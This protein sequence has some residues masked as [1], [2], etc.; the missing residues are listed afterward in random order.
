MKRILYALIVTSL[1]FSACK[2]SKNYLERSN[3]DRALQD[4]VK[5]LGKN[6]SD[7]DAVTAVPILYKSIVATRL[8]RIKSY[9]TGNELNRWDKIISEYNQLQSAYSSIINTTGAFKL[10]TPENYSTQL[11]E[12]KQN[13]AEGYYNYAQSFLQKDGRDNARK[14][15]TNFKKAN[16]Y[17]DGGYK[18]AQSKMNQAYENAIVDVM[19]NPVQDNSFFNNSG[20]GN[21]WNSYSNDYFQR[22][23]V[24][25]LDYNSSNNR[26][27]AARFYSDWEVRNKNIDVDW[28]VN[29][30]LRNL[31]IPFPSRYNYRQNRSTKIE[32]GK[33]TTGKPTYQT[34]YATVN[35]TRYSFTAVGSMDV[36]IKDIVTPKTVSTR[37]FREDY[38]WQ[39]ETA[40]YTGDS[41]ALTNNDWEAINNRNYR[42]PRREQIVEELYKKLYNQI[43]NHIRYTVEW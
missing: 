30:I 43:L 26:N 13:A 22:A 29:L 27:Y 31:D 20:W 9:Q 35:L 25:D 36:Q 10:V 1:L 34:V 18:D 5:R 28:E 24:R 8:A 2:S 42:E 33:D 32:T 38:R 16:T 37:S 11:L 7:E 3:E 40:S 4:A 41:R 17:L 19:I 12:A 23:L 6:A 39:E 21:S 14:A 15:Y